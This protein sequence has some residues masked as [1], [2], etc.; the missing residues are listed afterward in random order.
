MSE[1]RQNQ[2]HGRRCT[3]GIAHYVIAPLSVD[4]DRASRICGGSIVSVPKKVHA[5]TAVVKFTLS[6]HERVK[7]T[8]NKVTIAAPAT[9]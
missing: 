3:H 5:N 1:L 4:R 7:L 9:A 6:G 8:I 2:S